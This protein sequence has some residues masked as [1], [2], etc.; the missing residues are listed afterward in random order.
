[1]SFVVIQV[2]LENCFYHIMEIKVVRL[3]W[4]GLELLK[5]CASCAA[6]KIICEITVLQADHLKELIAFFS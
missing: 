1:M 5:S 2:S 6:N 4:C 3:S